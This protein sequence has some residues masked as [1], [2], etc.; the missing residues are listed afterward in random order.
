M[1]ELAPAAEVDAFHDALT[2][3][4]N[5]RL[6]D[7]R[8]AQAVH[9][10][11]RRARQLAV[12]LMDLD[13]FKQ[14]NDTL[15]HAAGDAVLR[16]VALRLRR[17]VRKPDTVARHGA[18][19]FAVVLS[20]LHAESGCRLV[21][22]RLLR[23]MTDEIRAAGRPVALALSLGISMF[24]ADADDGEGLLRSAGVALQRAKQAGHNQYAFYAR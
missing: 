3:L 8:L 13:N 10:A 21:A 12:L 20:D 17:C 24:P 22:D 6:L 15:G 5:R 9:L 2:G 11:R 7:D 16:E 18:D 1:D 14:V 23:V 19:E 4:P